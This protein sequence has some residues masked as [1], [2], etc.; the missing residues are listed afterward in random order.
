[1]SSSASALSRMDYARVLLVLVVV[2]GLHAIVAPLA[3]LDLAFDESQY[4]L[5]SK[6]LDWSYYSKGPLVAWSIAASTHL[7][8]DGE[9]Q[10]RLPAWLAFDVFLILLFAFARDMAGKWRAAWWALLLGA[11]TP[12]YFTLGSVATTDAFLLPCWTAAT[13]AVFRAVRDGSPSA[14]IAAGFAAG[15]GTLTKMSIV[16]LPGFVFIALLLHRDTRTRLA[17]PWPWLAMVVMLVVAAPVLGWNAANDWVMFRHERGHIGDFKPSLERPLTL[18][19]TQWLILSPLIATVA[20]VQLRSRPLDPALR[21][22]WLTSLMA[23]VFFVAKSVLDKVYPNWPAPVYV[24]FL[25]LF[26][27]RIP[28]LSSRLRGWLIAGMAGSVVM[29][30]VAM[31][32]H[33]LGVRITPFKDLV[34]WRHQ[35]SE[36]AAQSGPTDF[37]IATDYHIASSFAF[38]WPERIPVYVGGGTD[39]R[40]SQF[41][42]WSGLEREAGDSGV[43]VSKL[44]QLP[45]TAT[46]A[47]SQC[48]PLVPV[49]AVSLQGIRVRTLYSWKCSGHRRIAWPAPQRY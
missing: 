35:A 5:W 17:T 2:T 11:T 34:G 43:I 32:P 23:G 40:R 10:V 14:W 44:D 41:N 29:I 4:W 48:M 22:L 24:S 47:F 42:L 19:S 3:G 30:I 21:V 31:F 13:W 45:A 1:M 12:V 18:V 15:L 8:G 39:W 46:A 36:I 37:L 7:F 20:F 9:W 28:A 26:A 25:V 49:E 16:L 38:Y 6:H 33:W 27:A